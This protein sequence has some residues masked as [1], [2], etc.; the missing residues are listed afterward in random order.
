[1]KRTTLIALILG[2]IISCTG[3]GNVET[4]D[5][6]RADSSSAA[7]TA[8]MTTASSVRTDLSA[9]SAATTK[10]T[11]NTT[12]VVSHTDK[13]GNK[14][15]DFFVD[16]KGNIIPPKKSSATTTSVSGK[17]KTT[18]TTKSTANTQQNN[19]GNNNYPENNNHEQNNDQQNNSGSNNSPAPVHT[20]APQ[21]QTERKTTTTTQPPQTT[22]TTAVPQ[23]SVSIDTADLDDTLKAYL[24]FGRGDK[25]SSSDWELIRQDVCNYTLEKYNGKSYFE[26]DDGAWGVYVAEFAAPLNISV[27]TSW[28]DYSHAHLNAGCG[29]NVNACYYYP[30]RDAESNDELYNI[31]IEI[32]TSVRSVSDN[33]IRTWHWICDE[34]GDFDNPKFAA[35]ASEFQF[36]V[37]I[38]D[39]GYVWFLTE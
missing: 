29:D 24:R 21:T 9:S 17:A 16:S 22:T 32:Q 19:G 4:S 20:N 36:N 39:D 13:N 10:A 31:A 6:S 7:Q 30:I 37:G 18:T 1:M 15:I 14:I 25:V 34:D 38:M 26:F 33:A 12:S 5:T 35:L 11:E 2:L 27:N 3:C 23:Q 28:T 8:S